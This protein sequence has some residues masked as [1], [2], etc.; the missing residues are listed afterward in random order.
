VE[1]VPLRDLVDDLNRPLDFGSESDVSEEMIGE[2][3]KIDCETSDR[4]FDPDKP[5][6]S[7]KIKSSLK[8]TSPKVVACPICSNEF[9]ADF[10]ET[11]ASNCGVID[12]GLIEVS[13][14]EH[15]DTIPYEIQEPEIIRNVSELITKLCGTTGIH[16]KL[17]VRRTCAWQ[18]FKDAITNKSWFTGTKALRVRF[19]GE[20]GMGSGPVR[21]FLTV[22]LNQMKADLFC[23]GL[24]V[25]STMKLTNNSFF[26][27]GRLM[28]LSVLHCGMN[29]S[30]LQD[31]CFDYIVNQKLPQFTGFSQTFKD[32]RDV[33]KLLMAKTDEQLQ[34]NLLDDDVD[35]LIQKIGFTGLVTK[36]KLSQRN[37]L[38]RSIYFKEEIEPRLSPLSQLAQGLDIKGLLD[39]IRKNPKSFKVCFTICSL[40]TMDV[41]DLMI[42]EFN[43]PEGSNLRVREMD[44]MKFFSDVMENLFHEGI[45]ISNYCENIKGKL[46]I[47][48]I[49]Q[50]ITGT[51]S[52]PAGGLPSKILIKFK[53][54]ELC[55]DKC[56]CLPVSSLCEISILIPM[57]IPSYEDMVKS[58]ISA[59]K[60]SNGIGRV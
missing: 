47:S 10:V 44:V 7:G 14:E 4:A 34:S 60:G 57:H 13:D 36:F 56:K 25:N 51:P 42:T 58:L 16:E 24:P 20:P 45:D 40:D 46:E 32:R 27:A 15:D 26:N 37:D 12:Y 9:A 19:L 23:D 8:D 6:C 3:E 17:N 11:H 49:L 1:P 48:D 50:F 54:E 18:D 41:S 38:L 35:H 28:G 2:E 52:I 33:Q 55:G 39:S 5:S 31:W 43:G 22:A 59:I 21:E 53:E 30:F 29:P